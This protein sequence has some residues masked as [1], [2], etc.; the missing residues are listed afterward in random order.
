MILKNI[1]GHK[2]VDLWSIYIWSNTQ[3]KNYGL[4]SHN[5]TVDINIY[6]TGIVQ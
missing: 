3:T 1:K 5:S 4:L 2:I 6:M